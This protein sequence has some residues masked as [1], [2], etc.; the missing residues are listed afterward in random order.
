MGFAQQTVYGGTKA[1]L[2]AMTRSWASELVERATVNAVNPGP[3]KTDM[4]A[5]TTPQFK[6]QLRPFIEAT[7]LSKIRPEVDDQDLV[8][9]APNAGGRPGYVGEVAGVV[10][11]LCT[12]DASWVTGQ[13]VCANGGMRFSI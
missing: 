9:D 5:G 6:N 2:E 3:I 13:V 1:A 7:P 8:E 10:G 4:W 12:P 11:M